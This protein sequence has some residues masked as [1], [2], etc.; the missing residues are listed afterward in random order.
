MLIFQFANCNKL[1][2]IRNCGGFPKIGGIPSYHF[3][4]WGGYPQIIQLLGFLTPDLALREDG[5]A[6][7]GGAGGPMTFDGVIY[8]KVQ[9]D[10]DDWG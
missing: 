9:V 8:E 7:G 1:E 6:A 2:G 10:V 5:E 4:F 3:F